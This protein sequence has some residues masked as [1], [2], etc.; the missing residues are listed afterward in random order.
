MI[1]VDVPCVKYTITIS[2]KQEGDCLFVEVESTKPVTKTIAIYGKY[3]SAYILD[4]K[5]TVKIDKKAEIKFPVRFN[6]LSKK[7]YC[8]A[9][10]RGREY[11][12]EKWLKRS[13][14]FF[15]DCA[16]SGNKC[17][18]K[19][20]AKLCLKEVSRGWMLGRFATRFVVQTEVGEDTILVIKYS[21]GNVFRETELF[22]RKGTQ[23]HIVTVEGFTGK[24]CVD[25]VKT[26]KWKK[27]FGFL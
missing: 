7:T 5:K 2:A 19:E 24:L 18:E 13:V 17:I 21:T 26:Y 27:P 6:G 16:W 20:G 10:Y 3:G 23:T 14:W 8:V 4:K 11:E 15:E 25:I 12:T 1:C 9:P 22:C